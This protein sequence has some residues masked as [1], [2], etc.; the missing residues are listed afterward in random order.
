[1]THPLRLLWLCSALFVVL[2]L[3]FV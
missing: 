1:M 3:G 2:G